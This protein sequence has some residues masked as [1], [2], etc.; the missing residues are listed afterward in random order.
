MRVAGAS[1][2]TSGQKANR[3]NRFGGLGGATCSLRRRLGLHKRQPGMVKESATGGGQFDPMHAAAQ[4]RNAD[5]T[6]KVP[7]LA[8]KRRLRGV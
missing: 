4:Q 2:A 7:D 5:F 1:Q 3:K 6:L 8:A